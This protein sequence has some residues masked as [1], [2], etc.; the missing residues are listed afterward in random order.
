MNTQWS[1]KRVTL[2]KEWSKSMEGRYY[3]RDDKKTWQQLDRAFLAAE[4]AGDLQ[5]QERILQEARDFY[6]VLTQG[7]V[8]P[9]G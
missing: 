8:S 7:Y 3:M 1:E 9:R 4:A 5:G 2:H 6:Q